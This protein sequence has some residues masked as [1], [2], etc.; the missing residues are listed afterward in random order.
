MSASIA[1]DNLALRRLY[2]WEK[3]AANKVALTQPMG[4]GVLRDYTWG[5]VLDQS[6]RMAGTFRAWAY[7]VATTS[8]SSQRTPHTG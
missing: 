3:T 8:P 1:D 6:R 2:H 5:E 4:D 7:S